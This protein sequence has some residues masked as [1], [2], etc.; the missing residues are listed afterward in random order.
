MLGL[1]KPIAGE[2]V[3]FG[4]PPKES[5]GK[6]G[7]VPQK[8]RPDPALPMTVFEFLKIA[9]GAKT[10]KGRLKEA[11]GE[12]GLNY[13]LISKTPLAHLSGGQ[14]QRVLVAR[15]ILNS[16]DIL[17]MDEPASGVDASGEGLLLDVMK[18]LNT[19]HGTTIV[20]ISHDVS[21]IAK[22]VTHVVC[23]NGTLVCFGTPHKALTSSNLRKLYGDDWVPHT[24]E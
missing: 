22:I 2:V 9:R 3:L 1:L 17:F 10:P 14:I 16:P 23:L 5:Y 12:V 21:V 13:R 8:F 20:L 7:Y 11:L 18:H 4:R 6:I 19:E 15:A 24:H